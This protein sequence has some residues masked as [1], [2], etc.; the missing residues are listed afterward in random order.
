MTTPAKTPAT[1]TPQQAQKEADQKGFDEKI[2]KQL[3]GISDEVDDLDAANPDHG[4]VAALY[5]ELL[6]IKETVASCPPPLRKKYNSI[7][8][9]LFSHMDALPGT[10]L[11]G[12]S[13]PRP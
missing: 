3:D 9:L 12:D 11:L 2:A 1:K 10:M 4:D 13:D 5:R 7:V 8:T 6:A